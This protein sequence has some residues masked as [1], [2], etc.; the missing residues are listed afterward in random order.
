MDTR[1]LIVDDSA[2]ARKALRLALQSDPEIRVVG[3]A[4]DGR[5]ALRLIPVL[6]PSLV[7]MD[8]FLSPENGIDVTAAIMASCPV[9]ILIV[10][11]ANTSKPKLAYESL[12]AGALEVVGKPPARSHECYDQ[13]C[14]QLQR[15]AKSLARVPVVHRHRRRDRA[16]QTPPGCGKQSAEH[17]GAAPTQSTEVFLVGA[18]TGGPP[19]LNAL[20]QSL[21]APL[22]IPVVVVQHMAP[23]FSADFA[24]WLERSTGQRTSIVAEP[25]ALQGG[26]IY[27]AAADRHLIFSDRTSVMPDDS[28]PR[29]FQRPSIDVLFESAARC[30]GSASAAVVLSGM[31][32]DGAAG[33]VALS[34]AGAVT[35]A[36]QPETCALDS[37]PLRAIA[38]GSVQHVM[39]P[40]ELGL[41]LTR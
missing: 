4:C 24:L 6:R 31:G 30:V 14:R 9:P 19:V 26:R 2:T 23:G 25:T 39:S 15:I 36:Q 20:L 8:V 21:G 10:T 29:G 5:S 41:W 17:H 32:C 27:L 18:S 34:S 3:E 33:M 22:P 38:T 12:Q 7:T 11:A 28:P 35:I 40:E 16:R 37:M 13:R 1:V